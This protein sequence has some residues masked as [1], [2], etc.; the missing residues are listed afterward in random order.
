MK[1]SVLL[2]AIDPVSERNRQNDLDI[3]K[4]AYHSSEVQS[5]TLFVCIRGFKTDG[6]NYAELAVENGAAAL[7]VER[8]LPN[9]RIPQFLVADGR[10]ALAL[11]SDC[12]Y[13]RP[14]REMRLFGVT[15]T[16][17]KTTITYMTDAVFRANDLAT[18]LIG[19]IMVKFSDVMVPAVL[20]TPESLDLQRY[21]KKMHDKG[22][23]HV[24]MEVSSSALALKRTDNVAFDVA[25]FTNIHR[26]HIELHGSFD[27]YYKAK[28]SFIRQAPKTSVALLNIDEPLI[29]KL[30]EETEAQV[31]A[32]GIEN[33]SG[34]F[35]VSDLDM[36]NGIPSF[37]VTQKRAVQSL[38]GRQIWLE[39]FRIDLAVPGLYS[40][41]NALTAIITGL[42]NDIPLSVVK[43]GI[44]GFGG[45]ERR[46]QILYDK[47]FMV[48]D[49]LLLNEDNID[50]SMN[51][52]KNL[53]VKTIH[54]V[55]AVR[56]SRGAEVNRENAAK[57]ADWFPSLDIDSVTLTASRSHVG[58]LDT[59]KDEE[60]AAFM[61]VMEARG[62]A[63]DFY[64]ELYDA[65]EASLKQV[66]PG[67]LLLI[68]GAHGM[69]HGAR[70][71]MELLKKRPD[72]DREA[73]D[74]ILSKKMLGMKTTDAVDVS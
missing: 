30:T 45:V 37:T 39:P 51:T 43:S 22:V 12:F 3:T 33:A 27:A 35:H 15:G 50:A 63:V 64:D 31:I 18:G 14:S 65:L 68:T 58:E 32:F 8:F 16:N 29:E 60:T 6:H 66:K 19:T 54:F 74:A 13:G 38:T 28:A 48:I 25:A 11:A 21:L 26:D 34:H 49:D 70:I 42:V 69:D 56:G 73:V 5:G 57:M 20:T 44:E 9:I 10:R 61:E 72:T 7:I 67:D 62:I 2:Q 17:G 41:Y 55:H 23:S 71:V 59:V 4:L 1:L 46:F 24:S 47:E 53:N 36:E 40:V 52:L